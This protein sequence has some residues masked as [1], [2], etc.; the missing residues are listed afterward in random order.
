MTEYL[1][2]AGISEAKQLVGE[3]WQVILLDTQVRGKPHGVLGI[4]SWR[5]WIR[6]C[7]SIPSAMP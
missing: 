2:A 7:A 6:H 4:T 5:R 3:H 1:H